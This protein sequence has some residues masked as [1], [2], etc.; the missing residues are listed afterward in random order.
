M[1]KIYKFHNEEKNVEV[2]A[3]KDD[4]GEPD[5]T[6]SVTVRLLAARRLFGGLLEDYREVHRCGT[7]NKFSVH[8]FGPYDSRDAS[9][10]DH[11]GWMWFDGIVGEE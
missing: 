5:G 7:T 9:H 8:R 10:A 11:I 2:R 3:K 6:P 1:S 4:K